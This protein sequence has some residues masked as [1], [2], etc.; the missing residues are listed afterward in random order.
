[1]NA[2]FYGT[3]TVLA[4]WQTINTPSA[5]RTHTVT[6][7]QY[8]YPG[9][10]STS[11][12][13]VRTLTPNSESPPILN[14]YVAVDT[15][16]LPCRDIADD[17]TA[18]YTTVG[19]TSDNA[20]D[21][22]LDVVVVDV[23]GQLLVVNHATGFP[24]IW[25][26]PPET[27]RDWGRILGSAVDRAQAVSILDSVANGALSGGPLMVDPDGPGW[28]LAYSPDA[29]APALTAGFWAAWRDSRLS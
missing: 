23:T 6:F 16:T 18:A 11:K 29:G 17:Q 1:L 4:F 25:W 5:S 14:G 10:P 20:S 3:Y 12:S 26:D 13:A 21:R 7:K 8:D 28:L 24:N 9:G 22:C 2:R 19:V 27:D 15:I